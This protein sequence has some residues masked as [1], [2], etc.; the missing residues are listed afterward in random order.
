MPSPVLLSVKMPA[1]TGI[2]HDET[3]NTYA[4]SVA[5]AD[6][7]GVA[8]AQAA[9]QV[10]LNAIGGFLSAGHDHTNV[11]YAWYD[12]TGHLDGS[13]HGS[14]FF[15]TSGTITAATV[16]NSVPNGVAVCLS[17]RSAATAT[18]SAE[19]PAGAIPTPD[20]AQDMGA[21]ATHPGNI[22]PKKRTEGRI[23]LGPLCATA[24]SVAA[25]TEPDP[26]FLGTCRTGIITL[27]A[28]GLSVW[29]RRDVL[30]R[31]VTQCATSGRWSY[32]RL[33]EP[34]ATAYAHTP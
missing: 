22:R 2:V 27:S 19:G 29:S 21:P 17:L 24:Q 32:Q 1:L 4:F 9:I 25:V 20:A 5:S 15:T 10:F 3:M 8:A 34:R 18:A 7:T 16:A 23:F 33:R 12:L 11:Q 30:L 13:P 31:P 28:S 14:P 26:T 6:A